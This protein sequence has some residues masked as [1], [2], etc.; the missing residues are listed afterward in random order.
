MKHY[1]SKWTKRYRRYANRERSC[2][3]I[4]SMT[5][6]WLFWRTS[7]PEIWIFSPLDTLDLVDCSL[8]HPPLHSSYW[9]K[10]SFD[11]QI[12]GIKSKWCYASKWTKR[13]RRYAK[14]FSYL[15]FKVSATKLQEISLIKLGNTTYST[16]VVRAIYL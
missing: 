15:I 12:Y 8:S 5:E 11:I 9:E 16:T 14:C 6:D 3:N 4:L 7:F 1:G 13:Y 2:S 10:D